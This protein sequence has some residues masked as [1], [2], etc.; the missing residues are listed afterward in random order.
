MSTL[1]A[2][3]QNKSLGKSS[4]VD[5]LLMAIVLFLIYTFNFLWYSDCVLIKVH[6]SEGADVNARDSRK[7]TPLMFSSEYGHTEIVQ[8]STPHSTIF[9]G[10]MYHPFPNCKALPYIPRNIA[11]LVRKMCGRSS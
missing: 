8:A 4:R 5:Y 11:Y 2:M 3:A 6:F 9:L 10:L 1:S 7:R